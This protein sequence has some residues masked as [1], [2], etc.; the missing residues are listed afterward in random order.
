MTSATDSHA[1]HPN[2]R[3][4]ARIIPFFDA[5]KLYILQDECLFEELFILVLNKFGKI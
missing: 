5:V 3:N 1:L 2:G 4:L